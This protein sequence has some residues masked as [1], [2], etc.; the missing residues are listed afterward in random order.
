MP[1]IDVFGLE[2]SQSTQS[3]GRRFFHERRSWCRFVDIGK[4]ADL[5]P[6]LGQYGSGSVAAALTDADVTTDRAALLARIRGDPS[7]LRLPLVRHGERLTAGPS[8]TTWRACWLDR[9]LDPKSPPYTALSISRRPLFRGVSNGLGR[10]A[11]EENRACAALTRPGPD[12]SEDV[13]M[14]DTTH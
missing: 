8:E 5:C 2:G 14:E 1:K 13:R 10:M 11:S 3:G 7:L 4:E 12:L 9:S 6:E